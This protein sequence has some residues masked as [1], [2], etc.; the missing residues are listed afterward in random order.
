M[1]HQDKLDKTLVQRCTDLSKRG[2]IIVV[3]SDAGITGLKNRG[4]VSRCRHVAQYLVEL[5]VDKQRVV[6]MTGGINAWKDARL[7]GVMHDLRPMFAGRWV[8][9]G[10]K[11]PMAEEDE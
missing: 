8:E 1:F 11:L 10:F 9:S 7:D 6:R 5:G 4:H 2:K 3:Y